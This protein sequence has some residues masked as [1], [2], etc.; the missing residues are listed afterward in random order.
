MAEEKKTLQQSIPAILLFLYSV[1]A[2]LGSVVSVKE[3]VISIHAG[4]ALLASSGIIAVT[5]FFARR[6]LVEGARR[7]ITML[8]CIMTVAVV[9]VGIV[10]GII[11]KEGV[12]SIISTISSG[13]LVLLII[14]LC[15]CSFSFIETMSKGKF[16]LFAVIAMAIIPS[17]AWALSGVMVVIA[18]LIIIT[19]LLLYCFRVAT[20]DNNEFRSPERVIFFD[21]EG[22]QHTSEEAKNAANREIDRR[23]SEN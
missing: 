13:I 1:I 12:M 4:V 23:N 17:I 2:C 22:N 20:G 3:H 18:S 19:P 9:I 14:V 5:I 8:Y 6:N 7:L 16:I 21:K 11:T 10:G 15:N